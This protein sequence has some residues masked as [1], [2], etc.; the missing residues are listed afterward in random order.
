MHPIPYIG[1]GIKVTHTANSVEIRTSFKETWLKQVTRIQKGLPFIEVEYQVG[2]IPIDDGRG[3]EI[4]TKFA[5]SISNN[6]TFYTDSNG[7]E[8]LERRRDYRPS[9]PLK[10]YE[11]VAGNYYPVNA[12]IYI[13]D[14]NASLA[15][16][17]DRTQ[18]GGS[19]V[20]GSVELMAQRRTLADDARG[21]AEPMNE[22]DGGVT[23]Y[24]PFG[25]AERY[26]K[27][28]VIRGK[29]RIMVG[30]GLSGASLARSQMDEAFS[31][32]LMFVGSAP[33]HAEV[34]FQVHSFSVLQSSLPPNVM[35]ITFKKLKNDEYMVRLGHQ[36][37]IG[38]D[39]SLS[40]PVEVDLSLLLAGFQVK[41]AVEVTL[42]GNQKYNKWIKS[43]LD[44]TGSGM[45]PKS[46]VDDSNTKFLLKPMEIRTFIVKLQQDK[47]M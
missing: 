45:L 36:Y 13:E 46:E 27:G 8:F 35:L 19:L 5:T 32:P 9:W 23:P 25:K 3:K 2:P 47:L 34:P 42:T 44:W 21:V 1:S 17:V 4:V 11:Q 22:T 29:Y 43:R 14:Q 15:I 16:L 39:E 20:D 18:A 40:A 12:A 41:T 31:E 38:E 26:G 7:R 28:V 10:V 33:S 30:S 37:S 24:P 6:A